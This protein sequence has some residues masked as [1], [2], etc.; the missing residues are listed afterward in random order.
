MCRAAPARPQVNSVRSGRLTPTNRSD[1]WGRHRTSV[2]AV[3]VGLGFP[4]EI[5][6]LSTHEE[7]VANM[8][9]RGEWLGRKRA[10]TL[11]MRRVLPFGI[12]SSTGTLVI[13]E[14]WSSMSSPS[15]RPGSMAR[16]NLVGLGTRCGHGEAHVPPTE[17]LTR[18]RQATQ[19][20]Y[21][22]ALLLS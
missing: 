4:L 17:G 12:G 3:A 9:S 6:Q 18:L 7:E 16:G 8:D 2:A 19:V 21:K 20:Y 14:P 1:T 15:D 10:L 13:L 5:F 22:L 11:K